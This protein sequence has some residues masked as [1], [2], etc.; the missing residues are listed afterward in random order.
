M[1]ALAG[2]FGTLL[3]APAPQA[4]AQSAAQAAGQTVNIDL[5][6]QALGSA[7][8]T[9]SAQTGVQVFASGDVVKGRTAPAVAGR[10]TPRQ[11]LERLLSGSGLE[12]RATADG[13]LTV[14]EQLETKPLPEVQVYARPFQESATGPIRGQ[15]AKRS[16]TGTKTDT[17]LLE[18]PQ[19]ISVIGKEELRRREVSSIKE[20]LAFTPGITPVM[21]LDLREDLTNLR[22]FAVDYSSFFLDGLAT[23]AI[24]YGLSRGEPYGLERIEVL[25]GPSSMLYGQNPIG[26]MVNMVSKRPTST[27]LHEVQVTVGSHDRHQ[28]AFDFSGPMS[29]SGEW[30]YR[31]TGLVRKSETDVDYLR[32]DRTY[33]AHAITWRPSART[34]VTALAS[35]TRDD[36]GRSGGTAA[37]L[38]ASGIALP[39]PNGTIARNTNGGEPTFDFYK[40]E[41]SSIGYDLEHRFNDT[42]SVQ[43]NLRYRTTNLNYQTAYGLNWQTPNSAPP[44]NPNPTNVTNPIYLRGAF[45]SFARNAALAVDNRVQAKWNAGSVEETLLAGLDY[46][47]SKLDELRYFGA[48]APINIFNPLYGQRFALPAQPDTDQQVRLRQTGIYLQS[49]T[50][51]VQTW[52]ITA[53]LRQ[54]WATNEVSNHLAQRSVKQD[55]QAT[56]GRLAFT[57]LGPNGLA[58]YVSYSTAF[59]PTSGADFAGNAFSARTGKQVEL[60]VKYE[61]ANLNSLFT[62]AVFDITQD[63]MLTRDLDPAHPF[64]QVQGGAFRSKGLE[65][66]AKT[67]PTPS[68]DLI[69]SYTYLDARITK[70]NAGN[71]GNR[72]KGVPQ[73]SAA[74]RAD[75]TFHNVLPNAAFGFSAGVQYVGTTTSS[76]GALSGTNLVPVGYFTLPAFTQY[77]AG[78]HFDSGP[79]RFV[80]NV[81]N[82][83]DKVTYDCYG[84]KCWYGAGRDIRA[85]LSY[86]W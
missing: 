50:K 81:S 4:L 20:A 13:S 40:K 11:A 67:S 83:T 21:S 84:N 75:Y 8:T 82:L 37:F 77:S 38:P 34:S 59:T 42:W 39:N 29:R 27:P 2:V 72:P 63:N 47:E 80:L 17:P 85:T 19:S 9:L 60:G 30:S 71:I 70:S 73:N 51:F 53:G 76:D 25:R 61:P 49:Q 78:F 28:G 5:P 44:T 18:T 43:Q 7:I 74:A 33:L 26:G 35:Y 41:Q 65:L 23:P 79:Y 55:D 16:A 24:T 3:I 10:M 56:T 15:V 6:A 22:G 66:E 12:A 32:D 46:R 48:G 86:N 54:D 36:L 31:L 52:L 45:G 58:P 69:A 14:Q 1:T 64:Q 57:Y 62:A 68:L